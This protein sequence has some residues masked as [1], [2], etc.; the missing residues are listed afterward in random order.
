LFRR[1]VSLLALAGFLATGPGLAGV[2]LGAHLLGVVDPSHARQVHIEAAGSLA[3]A[4]H[5]QLG[6]TCGEGRLAL[7]GLSVTPRRLSAAPLP[8]S[9]G[10]SVPASA[11]TAPSLPRAPPLVG[12]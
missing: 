4:D 11:P 6:L 8:A 3:H 7:V 10:A 12:S 2:E 5:C 1:L 9:G